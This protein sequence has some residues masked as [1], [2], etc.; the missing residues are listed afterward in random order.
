CIGCGICSDNCPKEAIE[1]FPAEFKG[2]R[3]VSR[4]SIDFEPEKCVLCGECVSIC[5]MDALQMRI[6]KEESVPVIEK[7]VFALVTRKRW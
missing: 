7:N 4:S 3:A 2:I 5:P 1:Y 6:E